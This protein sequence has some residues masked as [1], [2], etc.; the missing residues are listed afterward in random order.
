MP[1]DVFI[2]AKSEDYPN[3]RFAAER[4]REAGL[5]V[6]FAEQDLPELGETDY[7]KAI[8]KALDESRH[9]LVVASSRANV[10]S[11]WVEYEWGAFLNEKR[12]GRKNGKL[13]TMLCDG[14]TVDKLP[15]DL[16]QTEARPVDELQILLKFF[17]DRDKAQLPAVLV[18]VSRVP[19]ESTNEKLDPKDPI[20]QDVG[21]SKKESGARLAKD[22]AA[23][24]SGQNDDL[25][26]NLSR[27]S[28][29]GALSHA[30]K[31]RERDSAIELALQKAEERETALWAIASMTD[32]E[33]GYNSY[34]R[35]STLRVWKDEAEVR[36]EAR[37]ADRARAAALQA[38]AEEREKAR[39]G[40]REEATRLGIDWDSAIDV[41]LQRGYA[42]TTVL[43]RGLSIDYVRAVRLIGSM[44]KCGIIGP[45]DHKG[46]RY[47]IADAF[48]DGE[49]L[50]QA[51]QGA[52]QNAGVAA[53]SAT[54]LEQAS[55]LESSL[56]DDRRDVPAEETTLTDV[57]DEE[58]P[59]TDVTAGET[60]LRL[61]S[62]A[63]T[64]AK[65]LSPHRIVWFDKDYLVDALVGLHPYEAG[66]IRAFA[67][68]S[69]GQRANALAT[70]IVQLKDKG[71]PL[72]QRLTDMKTVISDQATAKFDSN[73]NSG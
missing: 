52:D 8:S 28:H 41:V 67:G 26:V 27:T 68:L 2:S 43:Q 5:N 39:R 32:T 4:L 55:V 58:L 63:I 65:I 23:H 20:F 70:A 6:F 62:C 46:R 48:K 16:R 47:L 15:L 24:E 22:S 3:A 29:V 34:L 49:F 38:E 71:S 66:D 12:S 53:V 50:K 9:M 18:N 14:L 44:E 7:R 60:D 21:D 31:P 40:V 59:L 73:V 13:A 35:E 30:E 33:K 72:L 51:S 25:T 19:S 61:A 64:V 54:D 10:E 57:S 1:Y 37:R 42:T 56:E 11:F 17:R 45:A 69:N 36:I